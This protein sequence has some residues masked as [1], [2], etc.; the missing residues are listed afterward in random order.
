M[1]VLTLNDRQHECG[2][3]AAHI[4]E[5][6][7]ETF[8]GFLRLLCFFFFFTLITGWDFNFNVILFCSLTNLDS[9]KI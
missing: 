4:M 5:E 6:Y 9:N 7:S 8:S 3:S 1:D 2:K